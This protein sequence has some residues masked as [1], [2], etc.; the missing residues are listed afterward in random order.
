MERKTKNSKKKMS[1]EEILQ[2]AYSR[3]YR[4]EGECRD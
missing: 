1:K 3:A 2:E 4:Y